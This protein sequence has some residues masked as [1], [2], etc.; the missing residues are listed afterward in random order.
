M[1]GAS[2]RCRKRRPAAGSLHRAGRVPLRDG[3]HAEAR[4]AGYSGHRRSRGGGRELR[5]HRAFPGGSA[6]PFRHSPSR[7]GVRQ[8]PRAT[9]IRALRCARLKPC[10]A[11]VSLKCRS[12]RWI[13]GRLGGAD[14]ITEPDD[15]SP[16][17]VLSKLKSLPSDFGYSWRSS[18]RKPGQMRWRFGS[19]PASHMMASDCAATDLSADEFG[20]TMCFRDRSGQGCPAWKVSQPETCPD[21]SPVMNQRVRCSDEPWVKPSG[22]T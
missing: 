2:S 6:R 18:G 21:L 14:K 8:G 16:S 9:G 19:R 11:E 15:G 5:L 13:N 3:G 4:G 12:N 1:R 20:N 17:A 22:T 10:Y 7:T